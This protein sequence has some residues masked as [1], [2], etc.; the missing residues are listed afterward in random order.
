[1]ELLRKEAQVPPGDRSGWT[2]QK[3]WLGIESRVEELHVFLL[4]TCSHFFIQGR[5]LARG[6]DVTRH[7]PQRPEALCELGPSLVPSRSLRIVGHRLGSDLPNPTSNIP[8]GVSNFGVS[9]LQPRP[10][11]APDNL[12]GACQ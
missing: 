3:T 7:L 1:M 8:A 11:P 6:C 10:P 4:V 5:Y 2:A 9:N 12:S